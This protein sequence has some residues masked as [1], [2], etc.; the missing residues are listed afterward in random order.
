MFFWKI[1]DGLFQIVIE[2]L[3]EKNF[4]M[5]KKFKIIN[6]LMG[7]DYWEFIVGETRICSPK[8]F[9]SLQ[10]NKF[11]LTNLDMKKKLKNYTNF[12]SMSLEQD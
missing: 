3:D 4:Q 12:P 11:K 5:W 9:L 10:H 6:F 2:K 7:N 8:Y 1:V